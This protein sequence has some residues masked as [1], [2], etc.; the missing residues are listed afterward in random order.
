MSALEGMEVDHAKEKRKIEDTH[1][2]A[3][4]A[5]GRCESSPST[6]SKTPAPKKTKN[7]EPAAASEPSLMEVQNNIIQILSEK[8]QQPS[9]PPGNNDKEQLQ[10]N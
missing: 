3:C 4:K 9:R 2:Y 7:V 1:S 10:R 8:N 6:P 5:G